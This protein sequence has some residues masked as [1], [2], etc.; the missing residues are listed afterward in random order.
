MN[1]SAMNIHIKVFFV[2]LSFHLSSL[3]DRSVISGSND[4]WKLLSKVFI[5]FY[6]LTIKV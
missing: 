5:P 1:K 3:I 6:T 2:D 4:G